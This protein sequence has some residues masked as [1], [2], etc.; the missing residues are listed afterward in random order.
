MMKLL[1]EV[2]EQ[3]SCQGMDKAYLLYIGHGS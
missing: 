2:Q 3:I 1:E